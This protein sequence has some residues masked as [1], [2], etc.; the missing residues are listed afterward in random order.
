MLTNDQIIFYKENR[1]QEKLQNWMKIAK[2]KPLCVTKIQ[3]LF[4]NCK[5]KSFICLPLILPKL[6]QSFVHFYC[7]RK[8]DYLCY[9]K[10]NFRKLYF[11]GSICWI[12]QLWILPFE[13]WSSLL[14]FS[15]LSVNLHWQ[16]CSSGNSSTVYN[17]KANAFHK[18]AL[19]SVFLPHSP[20][21]WL[22]CVLC[23]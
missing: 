3:R 1:F 17:I 8:F 19:N 18:A 22:N 15:S 7:I 10:V 23:F 20:D 5:E 2:E 9:K 11:P 14:A 21:F 13:N 12:Y 6:W 4:Q 16:M